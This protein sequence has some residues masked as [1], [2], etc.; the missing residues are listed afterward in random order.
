MFIDSLSGHFDIVVRNAETHAVTRRLSFDNLITNIGLRTYC[1]SG[2]IN[3]GY[4]GPYCLLGKGQ[5]TPAVTDQFLG[6]FFASSRAFFDTYI[7]G[8]SPDWVWGKLVTSRFNAGFS[9]GDA[10][11][12]IGIGGEDQKLW[13]R[14]LILDELGRPTSLVV[15]PNEYLDVTYTLY[16]HPDLTDKQFTFTMS[17]VT[18][19]CIARAATVGY[20]P[21]R[22]NVFIGT[23]FGCG[24]VYGSQTLGQVT[25]APSTAEGFETNLFGASRV[26][27]NSE[28]PFTQRSLQTLPVDAYNIAGGIGSM[29]VMGA[30][31]NAGGIESRSQISISPKLPKDANSQITLTFAKTISRWTA[32]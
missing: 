27:W 13:C 19:S 28:T 3:Y 11:T 15:L 12:E 10:I 14:A 22:S 25:D 5:N 24:V 9:N 6:S 4:Y 2:E 23:P 8:V 30:S 31:E 18:Y 32:P 1:G 20:I 29:L 16:Y 26:A 17:G 21:L 7:A